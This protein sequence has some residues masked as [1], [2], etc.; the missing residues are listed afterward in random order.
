VALSER[1]SAAISEACCLDRQKCAEGLRNSPILANHRKIFSIAP[2]WAG[3]QP[4][5]ITPQRAIEH[6]GS[7]ESGFRCLRPKVDA[8]TCSQMSTS[9]L[10]DCCCVGRIHCAP[11]NARCKNEGGTSQSHSRGY[12]TGYRA[13]VCHHIR[14]NSASSSWP[15][16]KT[17]N[18]GNNS[19]AKCGG[20][21]SV[22][23]G[24]ELAMR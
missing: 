1:V 5:W 21:T 17:S 3:V 14:H 15:L 11:H 18:H 2:S 8:V 20:N 7:V 12:E 22:S 23:W 16:L 24:M 9:A 6:V 13:L 10:R 19:Q 4:V